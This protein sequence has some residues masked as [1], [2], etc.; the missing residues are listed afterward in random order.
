M[1]EGVSF[2]D[3]FCKQDQ[4]IDESDALSSTFWRAWLVSYTVLPQVRAPGVSA[5]GFAEHASRTVS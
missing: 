2:C 4:A 5:V 3:A 1:A